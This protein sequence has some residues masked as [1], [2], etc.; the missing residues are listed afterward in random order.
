MAVKMASAFANVICLI[1]VA[2]G[3]LEGAVHVGLAGPVQ[4]AG[5]GPHLEPQDLVCDERVITGAVPEA[6]PIVGA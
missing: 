1:T 5:R 2:S 6:Q 4:S 3:R